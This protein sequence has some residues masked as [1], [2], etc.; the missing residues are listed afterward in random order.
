ME[1]Y[2]LFKFH[3]LIC[4]A[5]KTMIYNLPFVHINLSMVAIYEE[6]VQYVSSL[7]ST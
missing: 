7:L 6:C 3:Y 4:I 1:F 2:I 5:I